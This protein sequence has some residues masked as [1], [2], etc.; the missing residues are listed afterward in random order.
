MNP[1][2]WICNPELRIRILQAHQLGIQLDLDLIWT[3][4]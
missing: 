1:G 2:L 3:F 4:L